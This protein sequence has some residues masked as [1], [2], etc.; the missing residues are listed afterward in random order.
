MKANVSNLLTYFLLLLQVGTEAAFHGVEEYMK[1]VD[2]YYQELEV[3]QGFPVETRRVYVASDDP[4][5][6]GECRKKFPNYVFYGD[7]SI[8]K[9]ASVSNRYNTASLRG[10]IIDIHM[11]SLTDYIV[12]TFSSQVSR[13]AYEIMQTRHV[14]AADRFKSLDDI[15]YYG[16]QDEHQQEAIM[17]HLPRNK[18][19][20]ELRKGDVIG[21][22][23]N[24]WTGVNKGK[25]KRTNRVGLYPEYKT[26][27]KV[28]VAEFPTYPNV[29]L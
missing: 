28:K 9:S 25:N 23:G 17:D 21:V 19:E 26:K 18:N 4:K 6:L 27:E 29:K 15:W 3:K 24:H 7:V 11:L 22:A 14:D 2:E 8:S 5:V 13:I 1:Y 20:I 10:I 16:G 12:C